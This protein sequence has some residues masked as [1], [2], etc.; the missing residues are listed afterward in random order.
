M[1]AS[2]ILRARG[3]ASCRLSLLRSFTSIGGQVPRL[4]IPIARLP[5]HVVTTSRQARLYSSQENRPPKDSDG[6]DLRIIEEDVE[7][8]G[9]E[10]EKVRKLEE[11]IEAQVESEQE[12]VPWY[13]QVETPKQDL[14]PL[15][16][17]QKIPEL[18]EFSPPILEPLL[19]HISIDLGLDSLTLL[20]LRKLDPPPALGA[21]LLMVI[22]TARSERHLHVSADRL[23]RWLRSKYKLRPDADGLLGRNELK[24]KLRRKA[25]RAKLMGRSDENEDD[26]MRTGWVCV[27]VG[28]VEP[29]EGAEAIEGPQDFV[30]FGR[31]TDGVRLVVQMLTEEKREEINLERLWEGILKRSKGGADVME[32]I[33]GPESAAQSTSEENL[34]APE[35]EQP[36]QNVVENLSTFPKRG[37]QAR[38]YHTSARR[39]QTQQVQSTRPRFLSER[40]IFDSVTSSIEAGNFEEARITLESNSEG[41]LRLSDGGWQTF[42]QEKILLH[43]Q[44]LPEEDAL[45]HLGTG[46]SD[47]SSTPFLQTFYSCLSLSPTAAEIEARIWLHC[48]AQAIRHPGYEPSGL[49][50]MF[51]GLQRM[52]AD[53]TPNAYKHLLRGV[54]QPD[55]SKNLHGP[56]QVALRGAMDIIQAMHDQ[57]L[58][59]LDEDLLVELQELTAPAED[60]EFID[61]VQKVGSADSFDMSSVVPNAIQRRLHALMMTLDLP[62]FRE[63]TRLRLLDHYRRRNN[64]IEFWDIWRMAPRRGKSQ[65]PNM[66]AF[67][68]NSVGQHK[69]QKACMKALRTWVPE[70]QHEDSPVRME[71]QVAAAVRYCVKVASP[72]VEQDFYNNP[73]SNDEWVVLWR[74]CESSKG[75]RR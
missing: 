41:I 12:S 53:I 44:T 7:E 74:M 38:E 6:N 8:G 56:T 1:V 20:D 66:Y 27:D 46:S 50:D 2:R 39:L 67:M 37:F 5:R 31:K 18:P 16:E 28:I 62:C 10:N 68:F 35:V 65:S 4:T 58:Q 69:N 57:G 51:Q 63:E 25:K 21:N 42:L 3:C 24:L 13:L 73:D 15:S 45:Q 60:S 48:F 30:G 32:E 43:L 55:K 19:Q 22:G 47:Y 26:G 71:G 49:L 59:I 40:A 75:L 52:G 61:P 64:W 36:T 17:R 9:E 29:A 23:C 72:F 54:L 34:L 11:A 70:M 33:A 14:K